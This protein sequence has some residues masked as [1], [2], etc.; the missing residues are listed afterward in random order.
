MGVDVPAEGLIQRLRSVAL[1]SGVYLAGDVFVQGVAFLLFPLYTR[2]LSPAEY[3]VL[4]V[5]STA[6]IVLILVL[7]LSMQAAVGRLHFEAR[8]EEER[9]QLYGTILV[10][11]ILIPGAIT[12]VLELLG[13]V[14][15][16]EVFED[17]PY[18]PYLR[19]AVFTAYLG[20]FLELPVQIYV[21]RERPIPVLLLT[22]ANGLLLAAFT[23]LLV[24]ILDQGVLGALRAALFSS[25]IV[26]LAAITITARMASF[27]ISPRW[28]VPALG[29]GLPLVPHSLGQWVLH[30]S[31]RFLL[32]RLVS[33]AQL[34]LYSLGASIGVAASFIA[35]ASGRA[36]VPVFT[37]ALKSEEDRHTVPVLATYWLAALCFSCAALA[38]LLPDLVRLL[39]T[40]RYDGATP[41]IP[42]VVFGFLAFGVY[43]IASQGTFFSMRTRLMPVL[44]LIAAASNVALNLVLVPEFGIEGSAAATLISFAVLALLQ[45]ILSH[46]LYPIHWEYA[47]AWRLLLA[48][49]VA[50]GVGSLGGDGT[51]AGSV[52]LKVVALAVFPLTL[53]VTGFLR[54]T[55]WS[56][57]RARL[58][59]ATP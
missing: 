22:A 9:R 58:G 3:G 54:D 14:G 35:H 29:F 57:L 43:M 13:R 21:A 41:V 27:R 45:G 18:A 1:S 36:F 12:L 16:L 24:V 4:A 40:D 59:R 17:I 46:R 48:T 20:V 44:T 31:D 52:A 6:T 15:A 2:A 42:W 55:E 32:E 33:P 25:G 10:F 11:L 50:F 47:R 38:L 23:V 39:T 53:A 8:D 37:K 49:G 51:T 26:A 28:L 5:T 56:W 7:G 30:L 19:Y 34:G